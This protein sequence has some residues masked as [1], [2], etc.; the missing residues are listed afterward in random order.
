MYE[1]RLTVIILTQRGEVKTEV[2]MLRCART[3]CRGGWFELPSRTFTAMFKIREMSYKAGM[4][5]A[6][7]LAQEPNL[8]VVVVR[9]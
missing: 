2:D 4:I 1:W 6:L 5:L 3:E 8:T 9:L 7:C